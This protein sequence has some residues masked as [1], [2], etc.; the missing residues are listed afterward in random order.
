MSH[1]PIFHTRAQPHHRILHEIL[2]HFHVSN[3][4]IGA[5][6]TDLGQNRRIMCRSN[7]ASYAPL[8]GTFHFFQYFLWNT[9]S[10]PYRISLSRRWNPRMSKEGSEIP[11]G[12]VGGMYDAKFERHIIHISKNFVFRKFFGNLWNRSIIEKKG[13]LKDWIFGAVFEKVFAKLWRIM[14]FWSFFE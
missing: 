5:S 12:P 14:R 10:Q 3:F 8:T 7:L 11:R 4:S 13:V 1:F 9:G 6:V 2:I